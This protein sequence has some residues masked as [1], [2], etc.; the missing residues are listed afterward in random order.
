MSIFTKM[1]NGEIPKALIY[2][3]DVCFVIVD[4]FPEVEGKTLVIPKKEVDYIF[5]L[6]DETY[7]HLFEISKKI[8]KVLDQTFN[9]ERTCIVVEGFEVPHVHIKLFP[10]Q[11]KNLIIHGGKE[12]SMEEAGEVAERIRKNL[13]LTE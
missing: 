2:E 4:K 3:D 1:L 7:N 10:V 8:G 9:T 6:D 11:D 13:P 12:I 5:D